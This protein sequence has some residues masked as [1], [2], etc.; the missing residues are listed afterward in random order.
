MTQDL[1]YADS[2]G[3][4]L[5]DNPIKVSSRESIKDAY[6]IFGFSVN[7]NNIDKYEEDF[8]EA[9]KNSKKGLPLLSPS[10][11]LCLVAQGKADSFVDFG[12]SF[13]G[14][15]AGAFI[16]KKAGGKLYNYDGSLFNYKETGIVALND[17]IIL[18]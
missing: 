5:N 4:Y 15:V 13:E 16:L 18:Q 1:F 10:L 12:C 14:Q 8:P 9:F 2:S 17:K 7:K 6:I 3:V 11:N